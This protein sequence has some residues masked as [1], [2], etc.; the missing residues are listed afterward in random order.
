MPLNDKQCKAASTQGKAKKIFDGGGMY[1]DVRPN[2][3]KYWRLKYRFHG[4][5]KL[6]A[7]GVYPDVS[8]GEARE[9]RAEAKRKLKDGVDPSLHKKE[10][11]IR[12][13]EN[14]KNTFEIIA[15][16]WLEN[17]KAVITDKHA[18]TT[19]G[20]L[21]KDVFP[22][23]G[24]YP[25]SEITPPLLLEVIRKVEARGAHDIAQRNLQTCG[26]IFRYA[27]QTSRAERDV[28]AD[29]RGA[30]KPFTK[31]HYACIEINELPDLLKAIEKNEQRLH[32]QKILATKLL[33]L[34]FVRTSELIQAK[35]NEFD[36]DNA[37]WIIPAERMKMR[38][39]HI[40]PLSRQSVVL[41]KELKRLN[42]EREWVFPN[43]VRPM[44]PMSN[45]TILGVFRRIGFKGRMTGHGCRALA[46]SAIKEKLGYRHEVVDR[47]L[48]H[49]RKNK[50]DAAYDR[51][52]F[53]DE[54]RKMMQEWANYL[55]AIASEGKVI[56]LDDKRLKA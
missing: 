3:S 18:R 34:T 30:L 41:L 16:E 23:I 39:Q 52:D 38:K 13:K 40:V 8:L 48:A 20:R 7:L 1:L 36:L 51:A 6:L 42:G 29:L 19:L 14:T 21:E 44:K 17:R 46:M 32:P 22:Y 4:T 11:K 45:N 54:R 55:D 5:E 33:M 37:E 56:S 25:M 53:L 31:N 49:A 27:I 50:I 28:A 10:Q 43:Q 9:K 24:S 35:W 12:A 15:I 47:Q 2:G 26:Q